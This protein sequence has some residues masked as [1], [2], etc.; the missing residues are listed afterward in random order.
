MPLDPDAPRPLHAQLAGELRAG[1]DRGTYP[2]GARLPAE[3]ELMAAYGVARGTVRQA[4]ATLADEG[5][6]TSV[7]G[8][9]GGTF[10][11]DR[12]T[13]RLSDKRH[14]A[15]QA[16]AGPF[17]AAARAQG[18]NGRMEL[19]SV[20]RIVA[21]PAEIAGPLGLEAGAAVVRRERHAFIEDL[22]VQ[23]QVS[24]FPATLVRGTPLA[25]RRFLPGGTYRTLR[26]I[27]HPPA[28]FTE[29]LAYGPPTTA[30]TAVLGPLE[31]VARITRVTVD[32][33]GR[34]LEL[35]HLAANPDRHRFVYEAIP[36]SEGATDA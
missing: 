32:G 25:R 30:E 31:A 8:R 26:A 36:I 11:R 3:R 1:I 22:A 18:L 35:L 23:L 34:P 24:W 10:V 14:A 16:E 4:L 27:G 17:T 6:I 33:D 5:L 12:R 19:V 21:A 13:V 2:R 28:R 15:T 29:E 7:R 9:G 20:E